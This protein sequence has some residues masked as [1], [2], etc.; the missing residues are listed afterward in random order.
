MATLHFHEVLLQCHKIYGQPPEGSHCLEA[1]VNTNKVKCTLVQALR[2]CTGHTVHRGSRGIALP[3]HDH[4]TRRGWGV[5]IMPQPLFTPGKD[6]IPIVQ[7]A[8][9]APRPVWT[10]AENPAPLEFD[11]RTVQPVTSR[12]TGY[13]TRPTK[14]NTAVCQFLDYKVYIW[15]INIRTSFVDREFAI[16]QHKTVNP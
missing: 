3:F 16:K 12:C 14:V 1:K 8:W 7:E 10:G 5:S 9:W 2:L 11:P 13:T 4:C 15:Y 6:P